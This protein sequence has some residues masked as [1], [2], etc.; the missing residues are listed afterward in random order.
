MLNE[1][2]N[3]WIRT[4]A[5]IQVLNPEAEIEGRLERD[6]VP[7]DGTMDRVMFTYGAGFEYSPYEKF[8]VSFEYGG[9]VSSSVDTFVQQF[10]GGVN[11]RF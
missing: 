3:M 11:Y 8:N 5:D 10:R 6:N 1:T 7:V 4:G 9:G 2:I